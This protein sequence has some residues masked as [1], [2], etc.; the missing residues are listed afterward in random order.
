MSAVCATREKKQST[1]WL[2]DVQYGPPNETQ[3]GTMRS[4]KSC[5]L[6]STKG[7]T[8]WLRK[9]VITST[10]LRGRATHYPLQ[11]H[12]EL[13]STDGRIHPRQHSRH[14]R[15]AKIAL[16]LLIAVPLLYK[17]ERKVQEKVTKYPPT[18]GESSWKYVASKE[19]Y[20][21][22]CRTEG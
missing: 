8:S 13:E 12:L 7:M 5:T 14:H 9:P 18:A 22:A 10:Q 17:L 15:N 4:P 1:T 3:I 2:E 20:H 11:D 6:S 19:G 21:C 16:T